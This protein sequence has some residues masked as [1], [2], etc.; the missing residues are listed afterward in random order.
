MGTDNITIVSLFSG[1]GGMDLGCE[2]PHLIE[3]WGF[4]IDIFRI[5][6]NISKF[7]LNTDHYTHLVIFTYLPEQTL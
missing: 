5:I 2:P 4:Y 3:G 1:C 7:I 6:I